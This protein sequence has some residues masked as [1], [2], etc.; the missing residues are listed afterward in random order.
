[1][2]RYRVAVCRGPD[3]R[4]N[5]ADAVFT[6][7]RDAFAA[8]GLTGNCELYRGGCYGL[9]HVGANVVIREHDGKPRDPLSRDDFQLLGIAGE[10]HYAGVRPEEAIRI[11]ESHISKDEPVAEMLGKSRASAMR[12]E[13]K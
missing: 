1:M 13:K 11:A 3:C 12:S 8:A 6:A 10:H 4:R 5:G 7:L 9:C 2:K